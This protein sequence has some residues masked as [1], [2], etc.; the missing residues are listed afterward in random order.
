[1]GAS[2]D[3]QQRQVSGD[4]VAGAG[5]LQIQAVKLDEGLATRTILILPLQ[6]M[7]GTRAEGIGQTRLVS[8]LIFSPIAVRCVQITMESAVFQ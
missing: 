3:S 6:P 5:G 4:V 8:I 1:M 7:I 2:S